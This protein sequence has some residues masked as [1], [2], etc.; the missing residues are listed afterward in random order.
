MKTKIGLL[1][2]ALCFALSIF[3]SSVVIAASNSKAAQIFE[4]MISDVLDSQKPSVMNEVGSIA[5]YQDCIAFFKVKGKDRY[6]NPSEYY[7][8]VYFSPG[9]WS[10]KEV[11]SPH[12]D[13]TKL[14]PE[15][16]YQLIAAGYF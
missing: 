6:N 11:L 10:V 3:F 2:L 16:K 5:Y 9:K 14:Y 13:L 15:A 4:P 7:M 1:F 12:N 8:V